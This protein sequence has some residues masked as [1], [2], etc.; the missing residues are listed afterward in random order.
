M[1]VERLRDGESR[2]DQRRVREDVGVPGHGEPPAIVLHSRPVRENRDEEEP[3]RQ[4]PEP[5]TNPVGEDLG[6][7]AGEFS[8]AHEILRHDFWEALTH[9]DESGNSEARRSD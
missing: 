9:S 2:R 4:A 1:T 6:D 7:S 8:V 3:Q 5:E